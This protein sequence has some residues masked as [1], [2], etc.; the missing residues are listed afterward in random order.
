[1]AITGSGSLAISLSVFVISAAFLSKGEFPLLLF[2][3]A[4]LARVCGCVAGS[5]KPG[6]ET[7]SAGRSCGA[8]ARR[9]CAQASL[10]IAASLSPRR[11]GLYQVLLPSS[12]LLFRGVVR[13]RGQC[14][15]VSGSNIRGGFY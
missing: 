4:C 5:P 3:F 7:M 6:E 11:C 2:L 1:M 8:F 10:G 12:T 9:G 14:E 13:H 15:C